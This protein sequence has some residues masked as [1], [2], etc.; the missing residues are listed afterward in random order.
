MS[1]SF[2][3]LQPMSVN[4]EPL[5]C[6]PLH[7]PEDVIYS[8][9]D[10]DAYSDPEERSRRVETQALR[11]L[12]GKSVFLLSTSLRGPFDS[13]SGW[14]NPWRSRSASRVDKHKRTS[15]WLSRPKQTAASLRTSQDHNVSSHT[16]ESA[17]SNAANLASFKTTNIQYEEDYD[18][19][20][21]PLQYLDED[22]LYRI[23]A[24]RQRVAREFS[25]RTPGHSAPQTPTSADSRKA[26][27]WTVRT[28]GSSSRIV[29]DEIPQSSF[30]LP[31]ST[32]V[33]ASKQESRSLSKSKTFHQPNEPGPSS[34]LPAASQPQAVHST[35]QSATL[36]KPTAAIDLS[37][38]AVKLYEQFVMAGKSSAHSPVRAPQGVEPPGEDTPVKEEPRE[39]SLED[40]QGV[41]SQ[42]YA[43]PDVLPDH[44]VSAIRYQLQYSTQTDGSFRFRRKRSA[45]SGD[46]S[47][48]TSPGSEQR[49]AS[50]RESGPTLEQHQVSEEQPEV[51]GPELEV[52]KQALPPGDDH[53]RLEQ[54]STRPEP[55]SQVKIEPPEDQSREVSMSS[56]HIPDTEPQTVGTVPE[57]IGPENALEDNF[58]SPEQQVGAPAAAEALLQG[59]E[60]RDQTPES[61]PEQKEGDA[62]STPPAVH[63]PIAGPNDVTQQTP[64]EATPRPN[65]AQR[66]VQRTSGSSPVACPAQQAETYTPAA[67]VSQLD[68]PTLIATGDS[69]AS[70]EP[71]SFAYFSQEGFSQDMPSKVLPSPRRLLWPRSQ[72]ASNSPG[73][74]FGF[75]SI[76]AKNQTQAVQAGPEENHV[77]QDKNDAIE[78]VV[79]DRDAP[80]ETNEDGN[81]VTP[82]ATVA[83]YSGSETASEAEEENVHP[84]EPP[85]PEEANDEPETRRPSSVP[86][87]AAQS[88]WIKEEAIPPPPAPETVQEAEPAEPKVARTPQAVQSP[89]TK[90]DS[91]LS[92]LGALQNP[93]L[94]LIANQGLVNTASQSPWARGD[95]QIPSLVARM[96][97][98]LSSP[99]NSSILPENTE[100][101]AEYSLSQ[102]P[103]QQPQ[104]LCKL[105]VQNTTMPDSQ[106][107]EADSLPPQPSTPETKPSSLPTPP[108]FSISVRSFKEFMTPSPR[109]KRAMKRRRTSLHYTDRKSDEDTSELLP[110]TQALVDAATTN[111]WQSSSALRPSS[112]M[113]C[114]AK[115]ENRGI[116]RRRKKR[117][118]WAD[119]E[120]QNLCQEEGGDSQA[121]TETA[122]CVAREKL[123]RRASSPPP[124]ILSRAKLPG[125]GEKFGKHFAAV[126]RRRRGVGSTDQ[127]PSSQQ[128]TPQPEEN[129]LPQ[130]ADPSEDKDDDEDSNKENITPEPLDEPNPLEVSTELEESSQSPSHHSSEIDS[131]NEENIDPNQ[132][133]QELDT[134]LDDVNAVLQNLDEFLGTSWDLDAELRS[135][136]RQQRQIEQ[137]SR[138]GFGLEM[139]DSISTISDTAK[140]ES[141]NF[142]F[143]SGVGD[144][145]QDVPASS[146]VFGSGEFVSGFAG[147]SR[148]RSGRGSGFG[149]GFDDMM[150]AGVWD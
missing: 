55:E 66:S 29:C 41:A 22:A 24:W 10:D 79:A 18:N 125:E 54:E 93:R 131:E 86:E 121:E 143:N 32:P 105:R 138:V 142:G 140:R 115:S 8:G 128:S 51:A 23:E 98:P 62:T 46:D 150:D 112:S 84:E 75:A 89:W 52:L 58:P 146:A 45:P 37:P 60:P 19:L 90:D 7:G 133:S 28:P 14:V 25:V 135:M 134:Q 127:V 50:R 26:I 63:E 4:V 120:G 74:L 70:S 123:S 137:Q 85:Q 65:S 130:E 64:S 113:P 34:L 53:P 39:P 94:S 35:P 76:P 114:T 17:N 147:A 43:T 99:A 136:A 101:E 110:S 47:R 111:P 73:P 48:P 83:Q 92:A 132:L 81:D 96:V 61:E 36:P 108:D 68:G 87:P 97:N 103:E 38:H 27:Q 106:G 3:W 122:S 116:K 77:V 44:P 126:S 80:T 5:R 15:K 145:E 57:Q 102:N 144:E 148:R 91:I 139:G 124:S 118:S 11:Y 12:E 72:R 141:V 69:F 117:V 95:S 40:I 31:P 67:S 6:D 16:F 21:G 33:Q 2:P 30:V 88:P 49:P 149:L 78:P 129:A 59:S 119:L 1:Q 107:G 104:S 71:S 42:A 9:S 109:P 56:E 20:Q 82:T 13:S 100:L